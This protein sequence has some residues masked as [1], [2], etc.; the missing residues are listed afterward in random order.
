M[1]DAHFSEQNNMSTA[2]TRDW[3][4]KRENRKK[5]R[6]LIYLNEGG[7]PGVKKLQN[8]IKRQGI[9]GKYKYLQKYT[10][11]KKG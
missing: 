6:W 11:Y 10:M 1:R 8:K 2:R 3:I 5:L 9:R 7:N 4:G